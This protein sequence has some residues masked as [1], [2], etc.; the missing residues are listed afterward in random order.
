MLAKCI[1]ALC[2]RATAIII[3]LRAGWAGGLPGHDLAHHISSLSAGWA[4][5]FPTQDFACGAFPLHGKA[6]WYL[7]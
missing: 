1:Y 2:Q 7:V 3:V 5:G 4:G 6:H